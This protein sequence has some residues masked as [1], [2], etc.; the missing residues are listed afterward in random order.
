[1]N[2][3]ILIIALIISGYF[4]C[5][6]LERKNPVDPNVDITA[7]VNLQLS[8]QNIHTVL[9]SWNFSGDKYDGFIIDRKIGSDS[10]QI[11]YDTV[12]CEIHS[13]TDTSAVPNELH[14]Y[15]IYSYADNNKSEFVTG[16][17]TLTFQ[18]PPNLT[19]TIIDDQSIK[20]NWAD[21]CSFESG[22][23]IDRD[24]GSGFINISELNTDVTTYID[25]G[26]T[27]CQSYTYRV[28]AYTSQ[29]ESDYSNVS[30]S[31]KII[32]L[33]PTNLI[34]EVLDENSVHLTW[35]D[36]C[37]FETGFKVERKEES[38]KYSEIADMDA[39]TMN[40][41]DQ[42]LTFG[43]NYY[44]QVK[45]H[46]ENNES[47]YSNNILVNTATVVD[48]DGNIYK[49][50]KIGSQYWMTEN[51]KVTH[52]R[53]G[54]AI[55][56]VTNNTEWENSTTGA[57]CHYDND[58]SNADTYGSLYNWYVVNDGRNIAPT[59]WHVPSD[60]EWQTL[61]DYLGGSEVAGGKM[62]ESG[63]AHWYSPNT[64]A[65]NE[66]GFSALP[67]GSRNSNGTYGSMGIRAGIW[68]STEAGG[69]I[70]YQRAMYYAHA[71]ISHI[72]DSKRDGKSI[73]CV[74]D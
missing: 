40:Y 28:K 15:R 64:G 6:D 21:N 29:N 51:L 62:K 73:R 12:A 56:K 41:T 1:M 58:D 61:V 26:L 35:T 30:N 45:A 31:I 42:G 10:W 65:T 38:G 23:R 52:Y 71:A 46:T 59:G 66:S 36:N 2:Y 67:G 33:A 54:D 47:D 53:N 18:A 74:R 4:A 50:A 5:E 34:V 25:E 11:A 32:I 16:N 20:L 19:A 14:T 68:S 39:N 37:T 49:V 7:P 8:Q 43:K 22:Y 70:A 55:P 17:I 63:T 9:L 60:E 13:Y 3:K 48:I 27:Y 44:Y 69:N 57:Y 72:G 24:D